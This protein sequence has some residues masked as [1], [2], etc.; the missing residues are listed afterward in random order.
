M[1]ADS[2]V[3][4]PAIWLTACCHGDE[5]GGIVVVQE[6]FR[7]IRKTGLS[8]GSLH[9]FP[10]MNPIGFE[11]MSRHIPYSREDLNRSF[12]GNPSGTL[13]ERMAHIIFEKIVRTEPELVV[14]LHT[15]WI[16]SIP[17]T[18]IDAAPAGHARK[19][20]NDLNYRNTY[21][22]M[23]SIALGCGLPVIRDSETHPQSLS[24]SLLKH[25][26]MSLTLELGE[27]YVINE[28]NIDTGVKTL[29]D[30]LVRNAMMA[31]IEKNLLKYSGYTVPDVVAGRILDYR[32]HPYSSSSGIIRFILKPGEMVHPGKPVARIYNA[33]GKLVETMRSPCAGIILGHADSSMA[34]PGMPV[35]AFGCR[36]QTDPY[37]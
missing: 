33:F 31:P 27:S 4:G 20:S 30:L 13:G 9:A 7:I 18:L 35:T 5:V 19:N 32:Q 14:D 29:C 23:V 6:I 24:Q 36:G 22:K 16:K 11:T 21:N 3:P 26:I 12:P 17:Y 25:G 10:L 34:Y 8:K 28:R 15:D 37:V 1:T 2:D